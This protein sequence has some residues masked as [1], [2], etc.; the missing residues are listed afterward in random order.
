VEKDDTQIL[1]SQIHTYVHPYIHVCMYDTYICADEHGHDLLYT[2][3]CKFG[4]SQVVY[5]VEGFKLGFCSFAPGMKFNTQHTKCKQVIFIPGY[6]TL[7]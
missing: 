7:Y 5:P 2:H 6:K 4:L 3:V 1:T